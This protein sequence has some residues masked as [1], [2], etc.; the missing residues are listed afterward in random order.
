MKKRFGQHLL[1]DITYLQKA[2]RSIELKPGCNIL[3]IGAGSGLLTLLLS[4][5]TKQVI[6][7]E[8]ERDIL[9]NLKKNLSESNITNVE[10]VEEDFLKLDLEKIIDCKFIVVGNIPYY[11][12]SSIL[13]KLFGE[14][15][16]PAKYLHNIE[17]VSLMMQYEVAKRLIAKPSTKDYSPLTLLVQYFSNPEIVLKVPRQAFYPIPKV[18]SAFVRFKIKENL[19]KVK[20]PEILKSIIRIGFQQRRKKIIN[21]LTKLYEDKKVVQE[22]FNKL[23]LDQNL[24][25]ENLSFH[26]FVAISDYTSMITDIPL[27]LRSTML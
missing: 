15:D 26:D 10:I 4:Q 18:D 24:R 12:T 17:S 2:F 5:K 9:K 16:S 23:N 11:I 13:I 1:T 21:S 14:I 8:P 25:A 27:R 20:N 19:Q 6:A 7:V 22:I 3:E